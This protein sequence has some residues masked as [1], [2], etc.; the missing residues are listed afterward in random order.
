MP[1]SRRVLVTGGCGFIGSHIVDALC[2]R[3]YSV[4]VLDNLSTGSLTNIDHHLKNHQPVVMH[5]CDVRDYNSLLRILRDYDAIFHEAALVSVT[6]SLEDPIL[7]DDINVRGTLNLLK[8]A[9]ECRIVKFVYASSSSVYGESETLPKR[10]DMPTAPISPYGVTKLAAEHYCTVFARVFGLQTVSLR[11]FNVYGPRQKVGLYSG[12]IPNFVERVQAGEPPLIYGD[13]GQ[14]RDFTFVEDVVDANLLCLE[15]EIRPGE[16]F[17]VA[18]GK[19][20]TINHLADLAIEA[21]GK[22]NLRPIHHDARS[23]DIRHS[24]ADISKGKK[25]LGYTPHYSIETGLSRF[26]EWKALH[27]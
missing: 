10:E 27:H 15:K 5:N 1:S 14:S 16:V 8:A 25:L 2:S 13:G 20:V 7:V 12:V 6:R 3:E 18:A 17:N 24:Y 21:L 11:Y 23:G 4:G 19:P 26:I 22:E 9:V